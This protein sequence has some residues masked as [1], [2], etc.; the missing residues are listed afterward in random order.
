MGFTRDIGSGLR[1]GDFVRVRA[2][3][4]WLNETAVVT[5]VLRG[6]GRPMA[7]VLFSNEDESSF[8]LTE[9]EFI[10]RE[11]LRGGRS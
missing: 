6:L 1:V 10:E 4:K 11:V 7:T 8:L 9:L 5:R 2:R 3:G